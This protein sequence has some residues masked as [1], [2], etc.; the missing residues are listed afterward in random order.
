MDERGKTMWET[1]NRL[2]AEAESAE[3]DPLHFEAGTRRKMK[4]PAPYLIPSSPVRDIDSAPYP[5]FGGLFD[6]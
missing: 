2:L 4:H 3:T 1:V 5:L 6:D